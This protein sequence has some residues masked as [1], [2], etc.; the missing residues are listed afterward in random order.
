MS[1]FKIE[2]LNI[3]GAYKIT[4]NI[5]QDNRGTFQKYF[6]KEDFLNCG[7]SFNCDEMFISSSKKNVVRGLH[8]QTKEPQIKLVNVVKGAIFDVLVDLRKDSKTYGKWYGMELSEENNLGLL[9][10]RGCAHGF[11]S[12][13]ENSIVMYHCDG[14]YDKDTDTGIYFADKDINIDWPIKDI[15]DVIIGNRDKDLMSFKEFDE[16]YEFKWRE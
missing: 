11:L 12:L 5:F 3:S 15:N 7:L 6:E 8:F 14:K 10:P 1:N 4:S 16:K 9:I 13:Q 2:E